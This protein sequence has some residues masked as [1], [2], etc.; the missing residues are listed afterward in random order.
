MWPVEPIWLIIVGSQQVEGAA[1]SGRERDPPTGHRIV[2]I[3]DGPNQ[4][5]EAAVRAALIELA[6]RLRAETKPNAKRPWRIR[7]AVSAR[8]ATLTTIVWSDSLADPALREHHLRSQL[9]AA[10]AELGADDR[11]VFDAGGRFGQPCSVVAYPAMLV[12]ALRDAATALNGRLECLLPIAQGAVGAAL[13][14]AKGPLTDLAI[15]ETD[16]LQFVRFDGD[17]VRFGPTID[18]PD[19][20]DGTLHAVMRLWQR[21]R[22][23]CGDTEESTRL[24]VVD[25]RAH[26]LASVDRSATQILRVAFADHDAPDSTHA[27]LACAMRLR[28]GMALDGS[29]QSAP[30]VSRRLLLSCMALLAAIGLTAEATRQHLAPAAPRS[31]AA[32]AQASAL[33]AMT[34]TRAQLDRARSVNAAIRELNFPVTQVLDALL[35]ARGSG[36]ALVALDIQPDRTSSEPAGAAAASIRISAVAPD[37]SAMALYIDRLNRRQTLATAQLLQHQLDAADPL[38]RLRFVVEWTWRN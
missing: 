19:L 16:E 10:G 13:E 34:P 8:W 17:R 33:R 27:A 26:Q 20:A 35:P 5:A 15:V 21:Q 1:W 29:A 24:H 6:K 31:D 28:P 4:T 9:V 11:V 36:V 7:A 2:P 38:Q 18:E 37:A 23:R 30:R 14:Q 25:L 3:D 32:G 22:L 12:H